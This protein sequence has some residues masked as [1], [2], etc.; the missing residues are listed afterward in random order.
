PGTVYEPRSVPSLQPMSNTES[1]ALSWSNLEAAAE[2]SAK[3]SRIVWFVPERYQYSWYIISAGTV[4]R[5][6]KR[7]HCRQSTNSNGAFGPSGWSGAKKVE[8]YCSPNERIG[9]SEPSQTRQCVQVF[10][11]YFLSI[12]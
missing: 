9:S 4:C 6:C 7:R 10:I 1:P 5:N 12:R 8:T 3:A 11:D 2:M